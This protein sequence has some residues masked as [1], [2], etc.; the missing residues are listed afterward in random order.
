MIHEIVEGD[1]NKW[2]ELGVIKFC[3]QDAAE[4]HHGTKSLNS[5]LPAMR[6][7][8]RFYVAERQSIANGK[9]DRGYE[10]ELTK[11]VIQDN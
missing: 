8:A 6:A 5:E 1:R 11:K 7:V 2:T 3:K 10:T 4:R 9:K